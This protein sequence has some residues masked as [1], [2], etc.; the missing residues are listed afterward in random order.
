MTKTQL[1]DNLKEKFSVVLTEE[2]GALEG[3]IKHWQV[4]VIDIVDNSMSRQWI[5]FYTQGT[6]A[7]WQ[8]A[9]PKKTP[10][11]PTPNF[12]ERVNGFIV[13]KIEDEVIKFGYVAETNE[14]AKRALVEVIKHDGS[15]AQAIIVEDT[16][17]SFNIELL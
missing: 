6:E 1:L 8:G 17:G 13:S 3:D 2:E 11:A 15:K 16:S 5:H 14:I 9:E 4:P 10:V 7:Y 12:N